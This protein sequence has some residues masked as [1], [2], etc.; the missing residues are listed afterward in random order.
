MPRRTRP[1]ETLW[2]CPDCGRSF[3]QKNQRH[4]CGV[5]KRSDI[6]RDRPDE[7]VKLYAAVEAFVKALGSVEVVTRE[8]YALFRRVRIFADLTVMRDALRIVIHLRRA[9][10]DPI[11][12]KVAS[13]RNMVSHVAKVKTKQEFQTLKPY[14]KEAYQF[15][16]EARTA[17]PS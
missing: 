16:L 9:V 13:G 15:S 3:T 7:I 2:K 4:A 8:R 11:F 17:R 6:L 1:A 14:L 5:G 10:T 12:F